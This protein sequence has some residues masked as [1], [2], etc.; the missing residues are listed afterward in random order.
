MTA[1]TDK[2]IEGRQKL[3]EL[4]TK[5]KIK[6]V[7]IVDDEYER[8]PGPSDVTRVFLS[9]EGDE[10][11]RQKLRAILSSVPFDEPDENWTDQLLRALSEATPDQLKTVAAL[12]ADLTDGE[13]DA[14][15]LSQV[16]AWLPEN[17]HLARLTPAEWESAA[18]G[19]LGSCSHESR[20]LFLFD[21]ELGTATL[22]SART[23]RTGVD[24]I[25]SLVSRHP[26]KFGKNF[27][28]GILSHTIEA[29][30]EIGKWRKLANDN[31][32]GL[33]LKH[34]M[35][36][37]KKNVR[38]G[39]NFFRSIRR[40]VLNIY[41]EEIKEVAEEN[42][43]IALKSALD[44]F[45]DIDP[46]DFEHI[47]LK[48][49]DKDGVAE[50][51][52][53]QRV[54]LILHRAS[55]RSAFLTQDRRRKMQDSAKQARAI[56]D[57]DRGGTNHSLVRL[58]KLRHDELFDDGGN[59]NPCHEPVRNGDIFEVGSG[60]DTQRYVLIG[61]P[62]DLMVRKDGKRSRENNFK[63]AF[64]APLTMLDVSTTPEDKKGV[65][66]FS[67]PHVNSGGDLQAIVRFSEATVANLEVLDLSVLNDDGACKVEKDKSPDPDA[68]YHLS[69]VKRAG[70][71]QSRYSK[72]IR[73]VEDFERR[74][75][76][77]AAKEF[78][79]WRMPSLAMSSSLRFLGS[80]SKG[81]I[82]YPVTRVS[83]AIEPLS[84]QMLAAFGE[85]VAREARD[86]DY[87][88][89]EVVAS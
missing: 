86:H 40:T 12:T 79:K 9:Q 45:R 15:V 66:F 80:F 22:P 61:Q 56:A 6:T 35:A 71:L 54:Y 19:Y 27:F 3:G 8:I 53:I 74:H 63:I 50:I 24:I 23:F 76:A 62:C 51:E 4:F 21:Q 39:E 84:N 44:S 5:L 58:R 87:S 36:L 17:I 26:E 69:W 38:A 25:R 10:G 49:S 29:N 73:E 59:I 42:F 37:S 83:R 47:V 52:T 67:L 13:S 32:A 7:V 60:A 33:K 43:A 65:N 81:A 85:F 18:D 55:A 2:W 31:E 75:G 48:S 34:F 78:G 14:A 89:L 68:F 72:I 82:T 11:R 46:I 57:V 77:D 70:L 20:T 88:L 28:C 16:E 30:D 1:E 64:L 41:C